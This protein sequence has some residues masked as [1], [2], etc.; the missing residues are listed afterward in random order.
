MKEKSFKQHL[1]IRKV[2]YVLCIN[3]AYDIL[4]SLLEYESFIRSISKD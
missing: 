2:T 1:L 4:P 3:F